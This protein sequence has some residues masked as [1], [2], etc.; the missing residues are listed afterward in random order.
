[1]IFG[2]LAVAAWVGGFKLENFNL[3]CW[4]LLG[5]FMMGY[6]ATIGFGCNVGAL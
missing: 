3:N 6:G 4:A 5:G 1:M 2:A